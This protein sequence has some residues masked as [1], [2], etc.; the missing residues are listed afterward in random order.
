[1]LDMSQYDRTGQ[2]FS[3]LCDMTIMSIFVRAGEMGS[4][5]QRRWMP[6]FGRPVSW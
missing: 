3:G 4:L 1:M 5:R 2:I 6:L